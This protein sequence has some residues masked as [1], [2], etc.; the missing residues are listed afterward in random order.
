MTVLGIFIYL[1]AYLHYATHTKNYISYVYHS[2]CGIDS[3]S[4]LF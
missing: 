1:H 3:Y 4:S 2:V